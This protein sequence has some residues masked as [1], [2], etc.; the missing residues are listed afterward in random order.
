MA[1][2]AAFE[3]PR[4]EPV[5][6]EELDHLEIEISVLTPLERVRDTN[7]ISVGRDGLMIKA[8]LALRFAFAAGGRRTRMVHRGISGANLSQS[9]LSKNSYRDKFAEIYKFSAVVFS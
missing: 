5:T 9:G 7:S 3:D 4:F 1:H 8:R 6:A 2:A